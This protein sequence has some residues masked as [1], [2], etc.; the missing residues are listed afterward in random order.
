MLGWV[1]RR[2]MLKSKALNVDSERR[3]DCGLCVG[4]EMMSWMLSHILL[5]GIMEAGPA[6]A[7]EQG[8]K[9]CWGNMVIPA[10]PAVLSSSIY[11]NV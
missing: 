10:V 3:K 9:Y 4:C 6:I 5:F 2:H 8:L 1:V 7:M 11:A